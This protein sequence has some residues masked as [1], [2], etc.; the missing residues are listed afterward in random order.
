[1]SAASNTFEDLSGISTSAFSNP[2]DALIVACDG[3]AVCTRQRMAMAGV[4]LKTGTDS[5]EIQLASLNTEFS[6][7]GQTAG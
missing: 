3:D 5:G 6:T 2:Y 1:M 4:D 7:E